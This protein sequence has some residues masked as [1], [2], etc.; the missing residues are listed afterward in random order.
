[1]ERHAAGSSQK[2]RKRSGS[3]EETGGGGDHG[4]ASKPR[5]EAARAEPLPSDAPFSATDLE[6]AVRVVAA[7]ATRPELH[8][9]R[10]VRPLRKALAPLHERFVQQ[11]FQ[12][13]T[14]LEFKEREEAERATRRKRAAET[15]HDRALINTR[16]LRLGRMKKL[17]ALTENSSGAGTLA[18]PSSMLLAVPDGPVF[19]G[20]NISLGQ[21]AGSAVVAGIADQPRAASSSDPLEVRDVSHDPAQ[22]DEDLSPSWT[23]SVSR[24]PSP[25]PSPSPSPDAAASSAATAE[26]KRPRS[27]YVCKARFYTLHHFY[28]QLCPTCASVNWEKRMHVGNLEGRV[29]LLTGGRVKIGYQC[30]LKLLRSKAALIVTTRFPVDA[31]LR[32]SREPDFHE[33]RGRL[34]VYGLDL[35]DLGAVEQFCAEL[36]ECLPRLDAI[37]N[38]ACQTVRRPP[39][40]YRHL[41]ANEITVTTALQ[42][43]QAPGH[44]GSGAAANTPTANGGR[45]PVKTHPAL[46]LVMPGGF[47]EV[48]AARK[49]GMAI[50]DQILEQDAAP[51]S[52]PQQGQL[53]PQPQAQS[54]SQSQSFAQVTS[55]TLSQVALVPGDEKVD[56]SLFP[57]GVYDVNAQQLDLR[58]ENSWVLNMNQVSTPELVEVMAI[59][60]VTP[61]ILNA[62]LKGLMI[63]AGK[64]DTGEISEADARPRGAPLFADA[65]MVGRRLADVGRY[66]V[67]VSAMEGKFYRV[68]TERHP[69]TNMAKAALNMMTRTSAQDYVKDGIYMNSV[70]TGWIN[71]EN[72]LERGIRTM[73]N[74]NFQTPIDE[75]DAAARV[76]DPI[77]SGVEQAPEERVWGKFLK[78]FYETEW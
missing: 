60:A 16:K 48:E 11:R 5:T 73:I 39:A 29:V 61:F 37:V 25:S 30:A 26:L 38:N 23:P 32:F 71:E 27:C 14:P 20:V 63:Q 45:E 56:E 40:Y 66:V 8:D 69:H 21:S 12:G 41:M 34:R 55:A 75:V 1:M 24:E 77:L 28:D 58:K 3:G 46:E 74:N 62:R 59:N 4:N 10:A 6:T 15:A 22:R 52:S 35:R 9:S 13:Q 57:V 7:L 43:G 65:P 68:K 67:N 36:N 53:Q 49:A 70:D 33:W 72:P 44:T 17:N 64:L 2:K 19:D 18:V 47:H 51:R 50:A 54:Q 76:L 42:N 78:D 31:S